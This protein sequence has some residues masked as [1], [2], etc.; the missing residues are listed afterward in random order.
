MVQHRSAAV[1]KLRHLIFI[2]V[3]EGVGLGLTRTTF[4]TTVSATLEA[5]CT[6][7]AFAASK[8]YRHP[9]LRRRLWRYPDGE[10]ISSSGGGL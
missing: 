4:R 3:A 7:P 6:H 1:G 2:F 10:C 9:C 5:H 8:P